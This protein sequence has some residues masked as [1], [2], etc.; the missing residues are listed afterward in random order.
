M[1]ATGLVDICH[2]TEQVGVDVGG[3]ALAPGQYVKTCR[4]HVLEQGW[5]PA[6]AVE[7]DQDPAGIADGRP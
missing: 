5:G 7:P 1:G 6:A 3:Q 2:V 4:V